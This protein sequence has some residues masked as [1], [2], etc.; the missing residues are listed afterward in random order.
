[1]ESFSLLVTGAF[2]LDFQPLPV[3]LRILQ[4]VIDALQVSLAVHGEI[5]TLHVVGRLASWGR[6][7]YRRIPWRC[8]G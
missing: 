2:L 4:E 5:M 7:T 1:M 8:V 6:D 3:F